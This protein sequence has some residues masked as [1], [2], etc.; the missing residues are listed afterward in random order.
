MEQFSALS[1]LALTLM[2]T[3]DQ[4]NGIQLASVD[5]LDRHMKI[6]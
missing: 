5:L 2:F 6:S 1:D 4:V 3:G